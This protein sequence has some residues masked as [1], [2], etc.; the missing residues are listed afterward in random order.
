MQ[1]WKKAVSQWLLAL[2]VVDSVATPVLALSETISEGVRIRDTYIKDYQEDASKLSLTI[3]RGQTNTEQ[4]VVKLKAAEGEINEQGLT[5]VLQSGLAL[6]Q[7]DQGQDILPE[8][9]Y[10]DEAYNENDRKVAAA[11]SDAL[12]AGLEQLPVY[13]EGYYSLKIKPSA[14]RPVTL[15]TD[16]ND[17]SKRFEEHVFV[18]KKVAEVQTGEMVAMTNEH[19]LTILKENQLVFTN[20]ETTE[21]TA[22]TE[23]PRAPGSLTIQLRAYEENNPDP[24]VPLTE[25]EFE[26]SPVD[27]P[28]QTTKGKTDL[29]GNVTFE[30]IALG[31]YTIKQ[32]TSTSSYNLAEQIE[33]VELTE[34]EPAKTVLVINQPKE[35]LS[36]AVR[37][38]RSVSERA[39]VNTTLSPSVETYGITYANIDTFG[40]Y[41]FQDG[42]S[43]YGAGMDI[44]W[45]LPAEAK[46]GDYFTLKFGN[47]IL[48]NRAPMYDDNETVPY[49]RLDSVEDRYPDT[50][51]GNL[52]FTVV[53]RQSATEPTGI[54]ILNVYYTK[55]GELTF[56]VQKYAN[57]KGPIE[58]DAIIGKLVDKY[59]LTAVTD[60]NG[61]HRGSKRIRPA[62]NGATD[63]R[64]DWDINDLDDQIKKY[65]FYEGFYP[66]YML[67]T[68]QAGATPTNGNPWFLGRKIIYTSQYMNGTPIDLEDANGDPSKSGVYINQRTQLFETTHDFGA[69]AQQTSSYGRD[70]LFPVYEDRNYLYHYF[71]YNGNRNATGPGAWE[72][73]LRPTG[74]ELQIV[75]IKL[76]EGYNGQYANSPVTSMVPP[77]AT[78]DPNNPEAGQQV[79]TGKRFNPYNATEWMANWG[80]PEHNKTYLAIIKSK[81][82]TPS[83]EAADLNRL[84]YHMGV[85]SRQS[86]FATRQIVD[87]YVPTEGF[88]AGWVV[89]K[90]PK[91]LLGN[92]KI[93]KTDPNKAVVY[94]NY[95]KVGDAI[96]YQD[97]HGNTYTY[98]SLSKKFVDNRGQSL[99]QKTDNQGNLLFEN[100]LH[101]VFTQKKNGSTITYTD[102][103]G[104]VYS[105][106]AGEEDIYISPDGKVFRPSRPL[107]KDYDVTIKVEGTVVTDSGGKVYP[108]ASQN[109]GILEVVDRFGN[110]LRIQKT[111]GGLNAWK[112]DPGSGSWGPAQVTSQG[113]G[114]YTI[115]ALQIS[116]TRIR[117]KLTETFSFRITDTVTGLVFNHEVDEYGYAIFPSLLVGHTYL[118]EETSA[119]VGYTRTP[120]VYRLT[121]TA[122]GQITITDENGAPISATTDPLSVVD[123]NN[124]LYSVVNEVV[125]LKIKKTDEDGRLIAS[126]KATFK[127]YKSGD[128]TN[129][130]NTIRPNTG[131]VPVATIQTSKADGTATL[132]GE[133]EAV[134]I[135]NI[136]TNVNYGIV[137]ETAPAG[138]RI[139]TTGIEVKLVQSGSN[140]V[141]QLVSGGNNASLESDN[142]TLKVKN[143]ADLA[144]L[145]ITKKIKGLESLNDLITSPVTFKLTK[146]NDTSFN[147]ITLRQNA[148]TRFVFNNLSEGVYRLE[149]T[150]P[151]TGYVK[152]STPYTVIVDKGRADVYQ[153]GQGTTTQATGLK[154]IKSNHFD[155]DTL[156]G[157][158]SEDKAIDGNENTVALYNLGNSQLEEGQ[159]W[160][161]DLGAI[162]NISRIRYLQGPAGGNGSERDRM[163]SLELEYSVDGQNYQSLG[164]YNASTGASLGE[165]LKDTEVMARYIRV[166]NRQ[167][168][169]GVWLA[170]KEMTITTRNPITPLVDGA[171]AIGNI[172][173][174]KL[175][176]EKQDTNGQV[177][178]QNVTFKLYKVDDATTVDNVTNAIQENNLIQTFNLQNGSL[179][180]AMDV[181]VLGKYALVE[182]QAPTGYTGLAA[183][184]LLE[185]YEASQ[186]HNDQLN[187]AVTRFRVL[188][189]TDKVTVDDSTTA[190]DNTL[191]MVVKNVR[192]TFNLK[193]LKRDLNN[194]E[195]GL[196]A[197]F[198]LYDANE[199][200]VISQGNTTQTGNS[201][202]FQNLQ[203]GIYVL[204]EV[205]PP[206]GYIQVEPVRLEITQAGQLQILSGDTELLQV[207]ASSGNMLELTV[208]ND[209]KKTLRISK[210]I[211]GLESLAGLITG[212]MTFTLSKDNDT[213]FQPVTVTQAANTD[214]VFN[215]LTYGSYTLV[216]TAPPAGY[217]AEPITYKVSVSRSG[218]SL[219]KVANAAPSERVAGATL[220]KSPDLSNIQSG[221]DGNAIDGNDT[222]AVTYSN[223]NGQGDNIP[224]GAYLGVDL[225]GVKRVRHIHYLQGN[226]NNPLDRFNRFTLEYSIDGRTY[227][228]LSTYTANGLVELDTD[229][230][231]RYI[232]VRN[233]DRVEQ[234]WYAVR[235]LTVSAQATET[236]GALSTGQYPIGNI[237][238]PQ[239]QVEK[240]DMS[241]ARINQ[242]VTFKLYK[243]DDA[244]TT[245]NAAAAIQESN[246]VQTFTLTNGQVSQALQAKVLGRY[247]L[248]EVAP[249]TG[250]RALAGPVLLDLTTAQETH[251]GSQM[252]T[253]TRFN[254][255]DSTDKVTIDTATAN[256]LKIFV[257]NELI[258]YNLLIKKRDLNNTETG[259]NARFELYDANET[260][261]ISQGNTTQTG[262]SLTFQNLQ[263][264][265][266]VLK[267][268]TPPSGYI[269]VD[270]VRLEITQAGQLQILSGDTEL[271]QVGASSGNT[272]ELTVKN[273]S[274][275]TLRISKRIKGLE[276]LASLITGNM[277]F[278]LSKDND[279]S[280]QPVTITQAA[281]T[282]FVFNNLTYGSYTLVETAPP[283]GYMAEPITYKVSVS[284]SGVS[285]YKVANV[286]PSE[287]VAGATLI[288]SGDLSNIQSGQDGNAIDGN[289]T[290]AVTYSNF[291][292]QGNNI[293][294]GAYLG[295]DLQGVKR[296]R[297]IHYLQGNQNNPLDRFNRF[298]LEYSIDGRT[299][300][301]LST[302]PA[303]G[304]NGLVDLDTDIVARYIRVRNEEQVVNKWYVV[305]ELTVSAQATETVSALS[306]GQYPI[307][308]I[309]H[310]QIQVEKRDMS[311]ARINQ[312]VTFELYKV[313]DATTTA[314][315]AAA[316]QGSNPVQTFTLTNGQESQALQ[317][318]VLG[319]YALVE[320]APPTGYRALAGPVLLDLTTAQETHSGS[321]MKTV[322]RFSLVDANDKVTIDTATANVLKIFVKNELIT[323]NLL[324]KKRDLNNTETGLNARFELYDANETAV[325]S[326]G[327]TTQTGNSLT[328]RNLRPGTYVLKEVTAPTGYNPI[329]KIKLTISLDGQI[330]I[331]EGPQDLLEGQ[332]VNANNEIEL[333]VKNRPFTDFSIEK[334]SNLDPTSN[335]AEVQLQIKAKNNGPAPLFS[336]DNWHIQHYRATIDTANKALTWWTQSNDVGNAVFKLPQGTYTIS[337][338]SAPAGYELLQPFDIIVGEDGQVRLAD[339]APTN[340]EIN[341]KDNRLNLKLTNIFKPKLKIIKVDSRDENRKLENA[342]FKLFGEDGRTQVGSDLVTGTT[343]EVEIPA[344]TPGTYYLQETQSPAGFQT[345]GTKYKL[346]IAADGT[347]TV[348]NG[349]DL[350]AV[351]PLSTDKVIQITVKNKVKTYRLKVKKRDYDNPT[352]GVSGARFALYPSEGPNEDGSNKVQVLINGRMTALEGSSYS[353]LDNTIDFPNIP[354][355]EYVLRET[356]APAGYEK[357]KDTRLRIGE[358]GRLTILDS[359]PTLLSVETGQGDTLTVIAK[360]LRTFNF[361]IKKVDSANETTL[362]DNARFS[363]YKTDVNWT[364]GDTALAQG[365]TSAGI[366]QINLEHGYYILKEEQ[367]PSG[368]LLNQK[369]YRF[370][371]NHDGSILLHNP[372][373]TVSLSR[374]DANR[375]ILFTMKNTRST[376]S[377]KLAK[378]AYSNSDR[379]LAA[380]FELKEEGDTATVITKTTKTDGEEIVFDNLRI[381]QTYLL[382]ET[383]APE[384]Y[385]LN[386]KVYRL[387][388]TDSGQVELLDGDDLLSLDDSNR[389]LLTAK[390]LKK[391]EYPKTGGF[392]VLPYITLGGGMML[393]AL[394]VELGKEKRWKHIRK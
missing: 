215:N 380:V 41:Q 330:T 47:Q 391:G 51:I 68:E 328:F 23:M 188:S 156:W 393:L 91:D 69:G 171:V 98:N 136:M 149:E 54:P 352:N 263:P 319:R 96:Q 235:E 80:G 251:S 193:L 277:T 61:R 128:Y 192:N 382:K 184:V 360:N 345:N 196:N 268:V 374:A 362:L 38:T 202:T 300:F 324:I 214:F 344:L 99:S 187:K 321:Q 12:A 211:K 243:V 53:T 18:F 253:V 58:G 92:F 246:L 332:A 34:S 67:M 159:W 64:L 386:T 27:H 76:F 317:A 261:V 247:A 209:S 71:V 191:K 44:R 118:L 207:G 83:A 248:V 299:Y 364:K 37:R 224:A 120:K 165:V 123:A 250:Y 225:Q 367:A 298:T 327:N 50:H 372:D 273:D 170:I 154:V 147:P 179:T 66:N 216:E 306:T 279:T 203:P 278:T 296:V 286:A 104:I 285:L 97:D 180:T 163:D 208:K 65:D 238:H 19:Y 237:Q 176:I 284:R 15:N 333:V 349:D 220:I 358:D 113:S 81:K 151:P 175:R 186:P 115:S 49:D 70:A 318:K 59:N 244:T 331:V 347:T 112:F 365:V 229:I 281:N 105:K 121:V 197:R 42:Y 245:A 141:W 131:A 325:I 24:K 307:G 79:S 355:G 381:G 132:Y 139:L 359:D 117:P 127:V 241:N 14:D 73:Y 199:T 260:A 87:Y 22:S 36:R 150:E 223:F 144:N 291:N 25:S 377:I 338:V 17:S 124:L 11:G 350:I 26:I 89:P 103:T 384:G 303:N 182:T 265:I 301:P 353:H 228:P 289:D 271:L 276:S 322:S 371:I 354:P 78:V 146:L 292:G 288:K 107:L 376:T 297:R 388:L 126:D 337:E 134:V 148:N 383:Q 240:R 366:Y 267:E 45:K 189:Q 177:I 257:K 394:A 152:S 219:Y 130:N 90:E 16:P 316:I 32:L 311:N 236:V 348:E 249:P 160:G 166:R 119:R 109:N 195:I 310:P 137:E 379:R 181:K 8:G 46:E 210:R 135:P 174:P 206:S 335:L 305:R 266:Y 21:I 280:F 88:G 304:A 114:F 326:Q 43:T 231:A 258:T 269:Q 143:R 212:N 390:N 340:A 29:N 329:Q 185:L 270:P 4:L 242:S 385:Q 6:Q 232:R 74:S 255:V 9:F 133:S 122:T 140:Y 226:Q 35:S 314:N 373:E 102:D 1:S 283:A 48:L 28:E 264:G 308:N 213:S 239:I 262:N 252:K 233:E 33:A 392:G 339:G 234:K 10:R 85:H 357:I 295:V 157:A 108:L 77:M 172:Q 272:L 341:T 101:K 274:K 221:Q 389:Q 190:T 378:R 129:N 368:Y 200:A 57:D 294:A 363:I 111:A 320:V 204:K 282:D 351:A 309:Q 20:Q 343:G 387:R 125:R 116:T 162:K 315:A 356:Q 173:N 62:G 302:Y 361:Q 93:Q 106:K 259:L 217:M 167:V 5:L 323:Y 313:D 31:T 370:Q 60:G 30:N 218:V 56:V 230:V 72:V 342:T 40:Y 142:L 169:N 39:A 201:L 55:A 256:V 369:E 86:V 254:L 153:S 287:R 158:N 82:K 205:T 94:P 13:G 3:D 2:L 7:N 312:S 375:L 346:I 334:V 95:Q 275:K 145:V 336:D 138:Y 290:T 293:P 155:N 52:F 84:G 183:P 100:N 161:V 222:T 194:T 164:T 178:S 168:K 75:D 227:F 198:E 63:S 110:L